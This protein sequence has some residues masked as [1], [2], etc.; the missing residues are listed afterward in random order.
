MPD[1]VPIQV[2][3]MKVAEEGRL[4][5]KKKVKEELGANGQVKPTNDA[6]ENNPFNTMLPAGYEYW[7]GENTKFM[8]SFLPNQEGGIAKGNYLSNDNPMKFDLLGLNTHKYG[9]LQ[10]IFEP[11]RRADYGRDR[12][13]MESDARGY[14]YTT[15]SVDLTK[16]KLP[17]QQ[18]S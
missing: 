14:T 1:Q 2:A 3:Y 17:E 16:S 9:E 15:T 8:K 11:P 18:V 4:K 7:K 10:P 6:S 5:N 13:H 12:R